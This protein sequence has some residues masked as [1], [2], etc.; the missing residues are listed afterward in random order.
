MLSPYSL[1]QR[2]AAAVT[3]LGTG[4][5]TLA[6]LCGMPWLL[7]EAAGVPWP[8]R[9]R[10]WQDLGE[11]LVQPLTD[12]L[13]IELLALAGWV[14]WGAFVFSLAR[15]T[16]WYAAHL[17]RLIR[18]RAAHREHLSTLSMQRAL[19]ALCIG[20]LFVALVA[21][22]RP[23]AAGAQQPATQ[24]ELRAQIA[25]TAP[26]RVAAARPTYSR[27]DSRPDG[28]EAHRTIEHTVVEGDTLW[29]L[30]REHVGDPLMWPRIYKLNSGRTQPDG[31]RL[32]DPDMIKPGWHLTIPVVQGAEPSPSHSS[33]SPPPAPDDGTAEP[34]APATSNPPAPDRRDRN[35]APDQSREAEHVD[36]GDAGAT[37]GPVGIGVGEAGLIGITAAA[38]LLAALR[39]LRVY[40]R[41]E[42]AGRPGPA[43]EEQRLTP[44]VR[45]AVQAAR[46]ADLPRTA[47]DPESLI[48]RR[49]PPEP[50]QPAGV[51][52]IGRSAGIEVPLDLVASTGGCAWTGPGAEPAARAL[53]TGVLTAAQRQRP[54]TARVTA[55]VPRDVVDR[56]LP[57]LPPAFPAFTTTADTGQAIR[58]AE[59]HLLAHARYQERVHEL[60]PSP[61]S[62]EQEVGPG[63]LLVVVTPSP[64]YTGQLE[65]LAARSRPGTLITLVLGSLPGAAQWH[66]AVDGTASP[67]SGNSQLRNELQLF[68]LSAQAGSQV[69]DVLLG[70]YGERP[71]LRVVSK[72]PAAASPEAS[73]VSK[74]DSDAS[75]EP[76]PTARADPTE[77][78]LSRPEQ[79]KPIRLHVL[80]PVHL[81]ARGGSEPVGSHLRA[82]VKEFLALLAAHPAG[83]LTSDIARNLRLN[84][85]GEDAAR[86]LKNL[87]RAVRRMLRTATGIPQAEFI[88]LNG[89][90]HKLHP[91]LLET[92]LTDYDAALK[93]ASD[94]QEGERLA[95]LRQALQHYR[96]PFAQDGDYPWADGIRE[97]LAARTTDAVAEL[98]HQAEHTGSTRHR[99]A[100]ILLLDHV[101]AIHPD[102]EQ[103]YQ[104]AIRLHQA[105]GHQDA[106][107]RI[108][109]RLER[110]L[111]ELGLEPDPTVQAL[112]TAKARQ[113]SQ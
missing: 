107:R 74:A 82:E 79:H 73:P 5:A 35:A 21:L 20:T 83:L 7:W 17:P 110:H 27:P 93:K 112:I 12:P 1:R 87:R 72:A 44:V 96:G 2:L 9:L 84:G 40:Q 38:G 60:Q 91:D 31:G 103:L 4:T 11:R 37:A 52:A 68:H 32:S 54:A 34:S 59:E 10:S 66:I 18:D 58:L 71:C 109:R 24:G 53:L 56:L 51:V 113:G 39:C 16:L 3:V 99:Q 25:V 26:A 57:G 28:A 106:A 90:L 8:E 62:E 80:G 92:D 14:C 77:P 94:A 81:Y 49:R 63:T 104:H 6:L 46:E 76:T 65:A 70:A 105:A 97:Q 61:S 13:M 78:Q 69:L 75:G 15:E 48:T 108:Y 36:S 102:N 19:A 30:A 88:R 64:A 95:L 111:T 86:E 23:V 47:P 67:S 33:P 101:I 45:N 50:P 42:R 89:E 43:Q 100:T 85:D 55:V 22:W 98:A 41:R 29:D